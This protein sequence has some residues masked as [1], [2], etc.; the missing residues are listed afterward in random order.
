[1]AAGRPVIASRVGGLGQLIVDQ[2]TGVLVEPGDEASLAA[3]MTLL[4]GDATRRERMGIAAKERARAF[5]ASAV[6]H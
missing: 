2:E 3:A 1:M 4:I 6:V 5:R